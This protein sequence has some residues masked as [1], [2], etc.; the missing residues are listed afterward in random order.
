MAVQLKEASNA[1]TR[2]PTKKMSDMDLNIRKNVKFQGVQEDTEKS[3]IENLVPTTEVVNAIVEGMGVTSHI[4][5]LRRLGKFD[6]DGK[7]PETMFLTLSTE[8]HATLALKKH[9]SEDLI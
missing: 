7:K 3:K 6:S 2:A 1:H 8:H 9:L 5:E 4:T